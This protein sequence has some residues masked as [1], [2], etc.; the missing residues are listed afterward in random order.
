MKSA[1]RTRT[2]NWER[3]LA[4]PVPKCPATQQQVADA[5]GCTK[6]RIQQIE[7]PAL[8]KLE[9]VLRAMRDRSGERSAV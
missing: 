5:A 4:L 1:R 2:E 9:K 3:F 8:K 6:G 7:A